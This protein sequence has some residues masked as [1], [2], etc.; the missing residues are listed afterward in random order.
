VAARGAALDP[1]VNPLVDYLRGGAWAV[2]EARPGFPTAAYLAQSP[3]LVGQGMTPLE[4][5]A[6]KAAQP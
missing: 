4:H 1:A 3:E 2:A 5:W 6:R